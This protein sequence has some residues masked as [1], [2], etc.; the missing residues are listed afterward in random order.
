MCNED[1]GIRDDAFGDGD[2]G[3]N[4]EGIAGV[5]AVSGDVPRHILLPLVSLKRF[6]NCRNVL[7]K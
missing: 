4:D 1:F 7:G 3:E 6:L 5:N 2:N